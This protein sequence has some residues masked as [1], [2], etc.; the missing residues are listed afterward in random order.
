MTSRHNERVVFHADD[1]F[2][3]FHACLVQSFPHDATHEEQACFRVIDDVV[4]VVG[5][6]LL[7]DRYRDGPVRERREESDSPVGGIPAAQGD[8]VAFL[9]ARVLEQDV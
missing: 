9:D 4:Y 5:F 3:R 1:G 6:E 8:L 2:E 7:E